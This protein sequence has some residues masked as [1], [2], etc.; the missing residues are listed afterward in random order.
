MILN[1]VIAEVRNLIQDTDS[2]TYRYT[3]AM[4]LKF[5]NQVLKRTAIFRPDLFS[6]QAN[7][8]CT[9]GSVVQSAPADS[10]RLMEVYYN[11]SGNGIIETTREVLDQAYPAW[12]TDNAGSTINWI[13][14]IRNPNK[15]FIYPKAP[16]AHQIVIEY[17][18]TP[19]D[20]AGDATVALLP[21]AYFPAIVDGTVF[22]AESIDNEH[23]NSNRAAL[24]QQSFSQALGVSSQTREITDTE[25][26]GLPVEEVV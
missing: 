8:T 19:P 2:T 21:D 5:A 16:S 17:A 14:N 9:A 23:V 10:I 25:G 22:L 1:N 3:D 18:Q 4:L 11:V 15:F 6:L 12:M 13:R 24:F 20:Y 7:L 26:G